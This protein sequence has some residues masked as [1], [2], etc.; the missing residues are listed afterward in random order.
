MQ[1]IANT[2]H[3][4]LVF[5]ASKNR[6]YWTPKGFWDK[7]V[8]AGELVNRWKK[9]LQAVSSGFTILTD[10]TQIKTLPPEWVET[11][12]QIQEM[13]GKSGLAASAEV[14]PPDV[15]TQMQAS[16]VSRSSGM[17]RQG[18]ATKEEAEKWLDS[19]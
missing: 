13:A 15:I 16:R 6:L 5:D 17:Q 7:T 9:A 18:F 3:Y 4:T 12:R 1:T 10:A 2:P 11:F 8:N 14:L 19:L